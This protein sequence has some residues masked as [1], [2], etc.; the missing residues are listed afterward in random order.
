MEAGLAMRPG[1][2]CIRLILVFGEVGRGLFQVCPDARTFAQAVTSVRTGTW[3]EHTT[4]LPPSSTCPAG[5]KPNIRERPASARNRTEHRTAT[6]RPGSFCTK[7]MSDS[8]NIGL[9]TR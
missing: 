9:E 4:R 7:D 3:C 1:Q 2:Y 5:R 6:A 8:S